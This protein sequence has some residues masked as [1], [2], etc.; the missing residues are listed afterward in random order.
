MLH[1]AAWESAGALS[2]QNDDCYVVSSSHAVATE[3]TPTL[4]RFT[5]AITVNLGGRTSVLNGIVETLHSI[6][7]PIWL[8]SA[9]DPLSLAMRGL[10]RT[11]RAEH[12]HA[13]LARTDTAFVTVLA[14]CLTHSRLEASSCK[15]RDGVLVTGGTGGIGVAVALWLVGAGTK[16]VALSSRTGHLPDC[17]ARPR[18][19]VCDTSCHAASEAVTTTALPATVIHAAGLA[20]QGQ[21]LAHASRCAF[22]A[23]TIP[24]VRLLSNERAL[25]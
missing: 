17:L 23:I 9:S 1:E 21:P 22:E 10:A 12:E 14:P 20:D 7:A 8:I 11:A 15:L 5:F 4:D 3:S 19:L 13:R 6:S 24:K 25:F 2:P 16:A 18:A